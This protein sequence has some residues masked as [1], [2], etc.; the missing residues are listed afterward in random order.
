MAFSVMAGHV[1]L[2][3]VL[4]QSECYPGT[5]HAFQVYVPDQYDGD[6]KSVV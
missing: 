1:M 2:D 4:D 6:R 3:G 5:E